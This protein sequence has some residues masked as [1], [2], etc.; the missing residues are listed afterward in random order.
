VTIGSDG[1]GLIVYPTD[2]G[3]A[4]SYL[5]VAHCSNITCT[6]A[7]TT[8]LDYTTMY[9]NQSVTIGADE[10]GLISYNDFTN[11]DLKVAHCNN[12]NCTGATL[13]TVDSVGEVGSFASITIGTDGLGLISYMGDA[14]T[15]LKVTHCS[16][17]FCVPYFRRR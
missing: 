15:D 2:P 17:S 9:Y 1:L 3:G 4:I 6:S 11:K 7:I 14:H 16:N 5:G 10:L 8:I 13:V 12:V